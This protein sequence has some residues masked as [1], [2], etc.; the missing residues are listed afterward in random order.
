MAVFPEELFSDPAWDILLELYA[1]H[2][3]QQRTSIS[4]VC[5]ASSV[6]ASTALRWIGKLEQDGFVVRT[7]DPVDARRSWL[8]LSSDGLDRMRDLFE[9]LSP[10]A[11]PV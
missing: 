7:A 6:P 8:A 11:L 1:L 3:E 9:M 10:D 5:V 2:L 4:S